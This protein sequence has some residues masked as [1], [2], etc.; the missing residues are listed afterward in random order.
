MLYDEILNVNAYLRQ[1]M[2]KNLEDTAALTEEY[3]QLDQAYDAMLDKAEDLLEQ[4]LDLAEDLGVEIPAQ[5]AAAPESSGE[6]ED[7]AQLL[8]QIPQDYDFVRA[9][10]QLVQE[11]HEAGF[12]NTHP[13]EL[14]SQAEM[15]QAERFHE[16]LDQ[17][18]REQSGLTGKDMIIVLAAT[19][20]RI[21]CYYA[22]SYLF[23]AKT[24]DA[25][26]MQP[27]E[28]FA[29]A[30]SLQQNETA[31][32]TAAGA[33]AGTGRLLAQNFGSGFLAGLTE[34]RANIRTYHQI[35]WEKVPFEL[36]DN[37]FF[38]HSDILGYHPYAGWLVG[39]VNI[40]TNTVTTRK[41]E[42]FSVVAAEHV[43]S[44]L[45]IERK[46]STAAHVIFPVV[47]DFASHKESLLAAV[48]REA[49]VLGA[50][51]APVEETATMLQKVMAAEQENQSLMDT[52][53]LFSSFIPINW[54][55]LLKH[56]AITAFLN[57]LITAVHAVQYDPKTDGDM[58]MYT[59]RTHK[60][61][62]ISN[63]LSAVASNIPA[64][65]TQDVSKMDVAGIVTTCLSL[66]GSVRFWIE[67]KS[68][69]LAS[70]YKQE[71]DKLLAEMDQ[72]FSTSAQGNT[73]ESL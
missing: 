71:A 30:Q 54:K 68:E 42:S 45:Q 41:L 60:I 50:T 24:P 6:A 1:K 3:E 2:R 4:V 9:F 55:S 57:Q 69:Y 44:G 56:T 12:T 20:V 26:D 43:A 22:F 72:Y 21:L 39:V 40:L 66:F 7:C 63:A 8:V 64:L 67:V 32:D 11:A 52:A 29:A 27:E 73:L 31:A 28:P 38:G 48:V 36:P 70:A 19:A 13:E 59:I 37:E 65:V 33:A 47:E 10:W 23:T 14:L 16:A 15:E 53:Q 18:F 17:R 25:A 51:H 49:D 61:L 5:E 46:L 35:L 58:K 62:T 34:S